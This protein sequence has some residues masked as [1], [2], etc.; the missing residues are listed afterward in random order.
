[1]ELLECRFDVCPICGH[2]WI[3]HFAMTTMGGEPSDPY[4]IEC[5]ECNENYCYLSLDL[6]L[7]EK[8]MVK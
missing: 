1:M 5:V 6:A 4:P 7:L 2:D 3:A 8:L